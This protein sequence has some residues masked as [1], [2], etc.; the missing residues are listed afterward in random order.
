MLHGLQPVIDGLD[1]RIDTLRLSARGSWQ[2]ELDTGAD[3]ELGRGEPAA[4]IAR[5]QA[6]IATL[7]QVQSR[8]GNRPLAA[9]DLRHADGYALRLRGVGAVPA[10]SAPTRNN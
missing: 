10:A 7:A 6:F 5:T 8:Y 2:I 3:I 4:V 1:A 9:A